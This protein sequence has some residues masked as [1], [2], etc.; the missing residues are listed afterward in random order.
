MFVRM[1]LQVMD[2]DVSL[3]G[4]IQSTPKGLLIVYLNFNF[5]YMIGY[6]YF[7]D[8]QQYCDSLREVMFYESRELGTLN[9]LLLQKMPSAPGFVPLEMVLSE[10][11]H[12]QAERQ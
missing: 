3:F 7:K 11:S 9:K 8:L 10:E 4:T 12:S 6:I 1:I 2:K 5:L